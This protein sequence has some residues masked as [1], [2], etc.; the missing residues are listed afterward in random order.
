M[1]EIPNTSA[2][3][4]EEPMLFLLALKVTSKKKCF[5]VLWFIIL[6]Y[7]YNKSK[8]VLVMLILDYRLIHC[9]VYLIYLCFFIKM[10]K[11]KAIKKEMQNNTK[12]WINSISC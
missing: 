11:I 6:L 4:L 1:L 12:A 10:A 8:K 5:P 9:I 2:F 7:E 3:F